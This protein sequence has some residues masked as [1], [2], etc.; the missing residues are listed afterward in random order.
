[1]QP[2]GSEPF[3][4]PTWSK[5]K[6]HPDHHVQVGKA[7]YSVPTR[8]IGLELEARL[9]S[10]TLRLYS[11]SVLVKTHMRQAPGRRSTDAN[12]YPPGKA[13][14]ARRS[15]EDV[16]AV[17]RSHGE[18]VGQY[19][20]QLLGG[21]HPW[22]KMRQGYGLV[23]LCERYGAVRVDALCARAL[24]FDVIDVPRLERMLKSAVVLETD[25]ASEGKLVVLGSRFARDTAYFATQTKGEEQ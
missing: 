16:K 11:G 2:L 7:L 23:R 12:D 1:M 24:A 8:Y 25:A 14:Y 13:A 17:A 9:D 22:T 19:A 20:E 3:D 5:A 15:V 6:V 18:H 4:V 21:E 10:S